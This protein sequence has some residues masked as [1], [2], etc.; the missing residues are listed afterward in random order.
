MNKKNFIHRVKD[1]IAYW[2]VAFIFFLSKYIR[3]RYIAIFCSSLILLLFPFVPATYT[4]LKNLKLIYKEMS[5]W[6]RLKIVAQ[7]WYNL[8]MFASEFPYIYNISQEEIISMISINPEFMELI[9]KI[10]NSDKGTI[11][12]SAH[13]SNW[14][15]ALRLLAECD[16]KINTVYRK[17]NNTLIEEK[18]IVGLREKIGIKMIVKHADAARQML[19]AL[20]NKEVVIMLVDQRDDKGELINFLNE[21]C[22]TNISIPVFAAKVPV[23]IYGIS[24]VRCGYKHKF[25]INLEPCDG[26]N[27]VLQGL[28]RTNKTEKMIE[29]TTKIN[30][31]VEKWINKNPNQW[32]WV[33]NRW[34]INNKDA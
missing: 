7:L 30:E 19:T 33:H 10:K 15:I 25:E 16:L 24:A 28:N 14:E 34:K 27:L 23:D 5:I 1:R 20:K 8:A 12:F 3:M 21:P 31:V 17:S 4:A 18:Y 6:N 32:F 26:V 22:Y 2:F 29:A 9:Q 11:I 13:F